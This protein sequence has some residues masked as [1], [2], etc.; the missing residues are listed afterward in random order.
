MR[1]SGSTPMR[2]SPRH[3]DQFRLELVEGR[4]HHQLEGRDIGAIAASWR[5]GNVEIVAEAGTLAILLAAA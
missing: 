1:P 3:D 2:R 5:Q 4:D